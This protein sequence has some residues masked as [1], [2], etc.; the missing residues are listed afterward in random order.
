MAQWR[1]SKM[2]KNTASPWHACCWGKAAKPSVPRCGGTPCRWRC[3]VQTSPPGF[4]RP[5]ELI[6]GEG[7]RRDNGKTANSRAAGLFQLNHLHKLLTSALV[8]YV[9]KRSVGHVMGDDDG[10]RGWRCLTGPEN[11]KNVWMRKDPTDKQH[12]RM[13]VCKWPSSFKMSRSVIPVRSKAL[14]VTQFS[15]N[16]IKGAFFFPFWS[17][18]R[19]KRIFRSLKLGL[20]GKNF[21]SEHFQKTFVV[22]KTFV[23]VSVSPKA[24]QPLFT[25]AVLIEVSFA[26]ETWPGQQHEDKQYQTPQDKNKWTQC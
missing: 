7:D 25:Q 17:F 1:W 19:S 13:N 2:E 3:P 26:R 8:Q 16:F 11:R 10:V 15:P 24:I 18:I 6:T 21:Q 14:V 23:Y 4:G 12:R 22:H 20:L 5:P 9:E